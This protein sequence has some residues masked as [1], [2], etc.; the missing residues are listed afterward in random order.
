[1]IQI[2][3]DPL[4]EGADADLTDPKYLKKLSQCDYYYLWYS[5]ERSCLFLYV[6]GPKSN[7]VE[8]ETVFKDLLSSLTTSTG[9]TRFLFP[10]GEKLFLQVFPSVIRK[11]E[12]AIDLDELW[13]KHQRGLDFLQNDLHC[14]IQPYD[15]AFWEI[16]WP[17]DQKQVISVEP[18]PSGLPQEDPIPDE[19]LSQQILTQ[20][21]SSNE[22]SNEINNSNDINMSNGIYKSDEINNS[23]EVNKSNDINKSD[24]INMFDDINNSNK[25]NSNDAIKEEIRAAFQIENHEKM[26]KA[27]F[28]CFMQT[29]NRT[30]SMVTSGPF[31]AWRLLRGMDKRLQRLVNVPIKEQYQKKFGP[32]CKTDPL[33]QANRQKGKRRFMIFILLVTLVTGFLL[34]WNLFRNKPLTLSSGTCIITEPRTADG[35]FID[36]RRWYLENHYSDKDIATDQ[37]GL[38]TLFQYFGLHSWLDLDNNDDNPEYVQYRKEFEKQKADIYQKYQLDLLT[39]PKHKLPDEDLQYDVYLNEKYPG[40]KNAS[41]REEKMGARPLEILR[42]GITLADPDAVRWWL[43]RNSPA[44][45]DA[46]RAIKK[47][48]FVEVL[49]PPVKYEEQ[50]IP[51][52]QYRTYSWFLYQKLAKSFAL[53]IE[54]RIA[55]GEI[56]RA[57]DDLVTMAKLKRHI[58]QV[59]KS[60]TGLFTSDVCPNKKYGIAENEKTI[61]SAED[62]LR[63][64]VELGK[65]QLTE[66]EEIEGAAFY[67]FDELDGIQYLAKAKMEGRA[68]DPD[69]V[70]TMFSKLYWQLGFDWTT[71]FQEYIR[72]RN[73]YQKFGVI[74]IDDLT[75]NLYDKIND[76][77]LNPL[78]KTGAAWSIQSRSRL[79]GQLLAME[80]SEHIKLFLDEF[81]QVIQ[82][83][84]MSEIGFALQLYRCDHGTFPPPFTVDKNGK[85]LH[86]WRVL[87]LPYLEKIDHLITTKSDNID[88]SK[89]I[90]KNKAKDKNK[91]VVG[92]DKSADDKDKTADENKLSVKNKKVDESQWSQYK[93]IRLDEP[94]DSPFN[95]QFHQIAPK[96]IELADAEKPG[97]TLYCVLVGKDGIFNRT[98]KGVNPYDLKKR[99]PDRD[100]FS[101][102]LV[103][104][105]SEPVCWMDPQCDLDLKEVLDGIKVVDFDKNISAFP[106]SIY[107]DRL[108]YSHF[109]LVKGSYLQGCDYH[110]IDFD[111][112]RSLIDGRSDES[113]SDQVP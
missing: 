95:K 54:F 38:R 90:D 42:R 56:S 14:E 13:E 107:K 16:Y 72:C 65:V 28:N 69:Q 52:P 79:T 84:K 109:F 12:K 82:G 94:W 66:D 71:L 1:M 108:N 11:K 86:S 4:P 6:I 106:N 93:K 39:P 112:V 7:F 48:R 77:H 75:R 3:K 76:I 73:E 89:T 37:N 43:D 20:D 40:E 34:Y 85:P 44:L 98:G 57:V 22:V 64:T 47:D 27:Y 23:N 51:S 74:K 49:V 92:K 88:K 63:L 53:R 10:R 103:T 36:Y 15:T 18:N 99:E 26:I 67:E 9:L 100:I 50:R 60:L 21:P 45:D 31:W 113:K 8:F 29:T 30:L 5:P 17:R 91:I 46:A 55:R 41:I 58:F 80:T 33:I 25:V 78:F 102:I 70:S 96:E 105:R 101:M 32:F 97:M 2:S 35:R 111:F 68:C 104:E 59:D 110:W 87:I 24:E 62:W 61:P 19:N 83:Q 81:E